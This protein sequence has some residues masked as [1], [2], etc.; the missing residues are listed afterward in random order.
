MSQYITTS[1]PPTVCGVLS[2][3]NDAYITI[4]TGNGELIGIC[5]SCLD[6]LHRLQSGITL[7]EQRGHVID[8]HI[9]PKSS[10]E[11]E[12]DVTRMGRAE[13]LPM[14]SEEQG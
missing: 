6:E 4:Y 14:E 7:P 9:P 5:P 3:M 8:F 12:I 11:I 10:R 1:N 13:P 2:C